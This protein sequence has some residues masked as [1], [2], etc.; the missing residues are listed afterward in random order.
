MVDLRSDTVTKPT[1][2]MRQLIATAKVGDDVLGDDPT[3]IA[4]QNMISELLDKEAALFGQ[5]C[6]INGYMNSKN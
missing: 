1:D 2:E 5:G 6:F 3:I 4:L